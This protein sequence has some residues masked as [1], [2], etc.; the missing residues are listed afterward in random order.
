[1]QL[2]A[3]RRQPHHQLDGVHIVRNHNQLRLHI[4]NTHTRSQERTR[5]GFGDGGSG[6]YG[7]RE[8]ESWRTF[9]V[10]TRWVTWLRPYL[11]KRGFFAS[12]TC[13]HTTIHSFTETQKK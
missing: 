8:K 5:D 13:D 6:V 9:L 10:S 11:M 4:T 7:D 3:Q 12:S 1:V 2:A